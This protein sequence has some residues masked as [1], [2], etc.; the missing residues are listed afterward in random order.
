MACR[1]GST[2]RVSTRASPGSRRVSS[3]RD[4][5]EVRVAFCDGRPLDE[6]PDDTRRAVDRVQA[7]D[8]CVIGTPVY[9]GTYTGAT[10]HHYL[11]ID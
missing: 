2:P 9:R 7:A 6:Y 11:A 10:D 1:R 8:A 4:L 3:R 5:R